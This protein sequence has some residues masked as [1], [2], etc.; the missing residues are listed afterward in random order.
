LLGS[1]ARSADNWGALPDA[2]FATRTAVLDADF[3]VPV[4]AKHAVRRFILSSSSS[5]ALVATVAVAHAAPRIPAGT[6]P[7]GIHSRPLLPAPG[8]PRA[9][10]AFAPNRV[11]V[12]PASGTPLTLDAAGRVGTRDLRLRTALDRLGPMHARPVAVS[13][14]GLQVLALEAPGLDP[15]AAARA[16][17]ASGAVRAACPD[18]RFRL[19]LTV[20]NDTYYSDQWAVSIDP[21]A[22][23]FPLA[24]DVTHGDPSVI[25]AIIDTGV[26]GTHP[27]LAAQMWHNTAEIPGNGIDD[28]GDGYI[29]DVNGW[30]FGQNDNDPLPEYT[31]DA[32]GID[33]GFHGTFCAAIAGAASDNGTGIT[34]AAWAS[35][36]M[37]LKV[38][39]PDSGIT[40]SAVAGAFAYAADHGASIIS[41]SLGGPGDPGVPEFFQALVDD[42]TQAGALV[43]AAAGND[44]DSVRTYPGACEK[45]LCVGATDDTDIR[46]DF[47][48]WGDWVDVA[49]PGAF[50][51]SAIEQNYVLSDLDQIIYLLFFGWDGETPYM[52]GDGTSFS[53]PLAAGTCALVR[54]RYPSLTPAQV[55]AH[56]IATGHA[57][58]YDH[59]MGPKLDAYDAVN[60]LPTGVPVPPATAGRLRLAVVPNP[61]HGGA[62]VRFTLPSSGAVTVSV[63]DAGGRR[64]CTLESAT[65]GAGPH[66]LAW[67]GLDASGRPAAVGIYFVTLES[68]GRR[69]SARMVRLGR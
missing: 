50:I 14:R 2:P 30:D 9:P 68:G 40:G 36:I 12:I 35:R 47:S 13:R 3:E 21:A 59:P 11:L 25:I 42:A 39:H 62:D 51:F 33:I 8:T 18:Y 29:D 53:C 32:S 28:D 57:V 54:A 69:L 6:L 58:A 63:T 52:Y 64:V 45:V 34:G 7:A 19:D 20:P 37:P 55:R 23:R 65:L 31:P 15:V 56:V 17:E 41:V 46:A 1:G 26:D 44:G 4:T 5:L 27:D 43:V 22:V 61:S 49:A 38:S 16:L 48:N 60:L 10:L 67:D 24:W 66:A